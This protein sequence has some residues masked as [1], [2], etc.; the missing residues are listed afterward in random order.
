MKILSVNI[1]Q[2][3]PIKTPRSTRKTGI[4]KT[5]VDH[6]V[7]VT[8][9]G[10]ESDAVCNTKHHGGVDQAVYVFCEPDY[11]WWA[12][13]LDMALPPG[14]FGENLTVSELESAA[15]FIGDRLHADEITLEVTAPRIPCATLAARMG[16]SRFVKR[17]RQGERPGIYCRVVR[18]GLVHA[19]ESLRLERYAAETIGVLEMFRDFYDGAWDEAMLRR[20]LAAPIAIR[21]R[22]ERA[23]QLAE[24][25]DG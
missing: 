18:E 19:G 3:Q 17:F 16:D 6:P 24:L 4:F 15:L 9:L 13:E 23:R 10:L 12:A 20:Y 5:P 7:R 22:E 25:L 21:D 2:P 1:A 8:A 14:T 11:A